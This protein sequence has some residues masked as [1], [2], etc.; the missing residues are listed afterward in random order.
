M[1]FE[2]RM[3][4]GAACLGVARLRTNM[5][6]SQLTSRRRVMRGLVLR[7]W[8]EA[9]VPGKDVGVIQEAR[10]FREAASLKGGALELAGEKV[11]ATL[12][13]HNEEPRRSIGRQKHVVESQQS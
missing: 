5:R 7:R 1:R 12:I 4:S 3:C 10:D 2:G 13:G 9:A 6:L 11:A 8:A